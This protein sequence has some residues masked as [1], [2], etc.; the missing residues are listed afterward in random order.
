MQKLVLIG[1]EYYG[2]PGWTHFNYMYNF[3]T[4]IWQDFSQF[5]DNRGIKKP[6]LAVIRHDHVIYAVFYRGG[7]GVTKLWANS[8]D[9]AT[10]EWEVKADLVESHENEHMAVIIIPHRT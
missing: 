1:G 3:E 2:K 5:P 7:H 10:S 9:E 6:S 8:G 4:Q